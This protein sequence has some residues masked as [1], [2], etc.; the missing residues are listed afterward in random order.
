MANSTGMKPTFS[1]CVSNLSAGPGNLVMKA[2]CAGSSH[3]RL[4]CCQSN[5]VIILSYLCCAVFSRVWLS[6]IPW[7][8]AHHT[9][10]SVGIVQAGILERVTTSSSRASSQPRDWIQVSH[11]VLASW[12]T[13]EAQGY[14]VGRL[15]LLQ[16]IFL[17]QE[18]NQGLVLCF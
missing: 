2:V 5:Q 6:S 13:R 14:S 4:H 18:L 17:T 15:S 11:W 3:F 7:T 16:G 8:V 12:A 9:P 10:L 1:C